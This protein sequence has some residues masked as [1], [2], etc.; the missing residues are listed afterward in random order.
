VQPALLKDPERL[1]F[2][3]HDRRLLEGKFTHAPVRQGCDTCHQPHSSDH[4]GLLKKSVE[5][6]CTTCHRDL[7][8]HYHPVRAQRPDPRTG[9]PM[10]CTGCHDPHAANFAGML[11]LDPK[12]ALCL[13]CHDP[14]ADPGP[15]R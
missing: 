11:R 15:R 6:T 9:E 5:E 3:C 4:R 14:S 12:Q 2:D 8:K 13:Q 1:C 10:T 7:S